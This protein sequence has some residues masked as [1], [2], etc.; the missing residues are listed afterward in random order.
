[1][2]PK[3][4]ELVIKVF[5]R[6]NCLDIRLTTGQLGLAELIQV[7]VHGLKGICALRAYT[8][9]RKEKPVQL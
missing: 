6:R 4:R 8:L 1:M 7:V 9:E 2:A 5:R 3:G